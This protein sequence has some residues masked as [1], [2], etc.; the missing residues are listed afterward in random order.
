MKKLI[1]GIMLI[2]TCSILL[3][4]HPTTV[5]GEAETLQDL[6]NYLNQIEAELKA[7]ENDKELTNDKIQEIKN[8]MINVGLDIQET[9]ATID[10][11]ESEIE[12]LNIDIAKKDA[13]I[14][15]IMSYIQLTSGKNVYLEY[16][17]GAQN[18][19]DFIY[20]ISIS[21]QVTEY[22]DNLI[23]QMNRTIEEKNQKTKDMNDKLVTLEKQQQNLISEQNK[24]GSKMN[25]LDE[26]IFD[27]QEEIKEAKKTIKNYEAL[28][29]KVTDL[30]AT[31]SKIPPDSDFLRPVIAGRITSGYGIRKD[32][33]SGQYVWHYALDIGGNNMGTAVY[34]TAAGRVVSIVRPSR[35]N[36]ANSSCGGN[37]VVIQH[38]V[39]GKY[40]AS[41]YVHLHTVSVS[42]N[43]QVNANT[44][45]G[46]V[47]GGELY[48][49][50][51]TG[52]H[53]HFDIGKGIYAQ[54]FYSFRAP[55]TIDP[56]SLMNFPG[57]GV[58]F[59]SRYQK[60]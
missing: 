55:Y 46:T 24:L 40:Y 39:N 8:N 50:C 38:Y 28:G 60:Y 37:M 48:D 18:L 56:R 11:L 15:K 14:K 31:C 47:G 29:C 13:E 45:I 57:V 7:K 42:I 52:P 3:Y 25:V 30:L 9:E 27:I 17:F 35:P 1:F 44:V 20:R 23:K 16:I 26:N 58:T 6:Y 59:N 36:V 10:T 32:P 41:R 4:S 5:L 19:T 43:Q 34:A 54:D 53:L 21:E 49:R 12:A 51:S 33:F 22:N 2:L